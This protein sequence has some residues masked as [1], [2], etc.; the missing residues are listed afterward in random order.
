MLACV[1]N[2][3]K[4]NLQISTAFERRKGEREIEKNSYCIDHS[5]QETGL[6]FTSPE[7]LQSCNAL[8]TDAD[9]NIIRIRKM[10]CVKDC[11]QRCSNNVT[12]HDHWNPLSSEPG[13][14]YKSKLPVSR[15][16]LIT[17]CDNKQTSKNS[18]DNCD[19]HESAEISCS[20]QLRTHGV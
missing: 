9:M 15:L 5:G 12:T 11:Q 16:M 17:V 6:R 3:P 13:R 19:K 4:S 14:W 2:Q 8:A 10:S 20:F 18:S 7:H 1:G